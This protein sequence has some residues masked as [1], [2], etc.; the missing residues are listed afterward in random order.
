[1]TTLPDRPLL[2]RRHLHPRRLR[3]LLPRPSRLHRP[4]LFLF[5]IPPLGQK[6]ET[7][8]EIELAQQLRC[9]RV[10]GQFGRGAH[11]AVAGEEKG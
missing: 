4:L 6:S 10:P 1:M 9:H 5:Q 7:E 11:D 8:I 2:H 3:R